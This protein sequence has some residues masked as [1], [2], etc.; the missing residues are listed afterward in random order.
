[1]WL[2]SWVWGWAWVMLQRGLVLKHCFLGICRRCWVLALQD[3]ENSAQNCCAERWAVVLSVL[4]LLWLARV[5]RAP[6]LFPV[7]FRASWCAHARPQ[8]Q[9]TA[10]YGGFLHLRFRAGLLAVL[11][12]L[13]FLGPLARARDPM[14]AFWLGPGWGPE[15]W[16]PRHH[17]G[18]GWA[19]CITYVSHAKN[20]T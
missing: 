13:L 20:M 9:N 7:G 8:A 14:S 6:C 4:L 16:H 17:L 2:T 3:A 10:I 19:T 12:G 18:L 5:L 11:F 15:S 1:M